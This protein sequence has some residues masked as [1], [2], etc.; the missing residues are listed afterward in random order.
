MLARRAR[1]ESHTPLRRKTRLRQRSGIAGKFAKMRKPLPRRRSTPRRRPAEYINEAYLAWLRTQPCRFPDCRNP[2]E[3]H[4]L[5]HDE[6]GA[7][8]GRNVK[9]DRRAISLCRVHH[10][11][12]LHRMPWVLRFVVH[13][14]LRAWQD[15]ELAIQRAEFLARV[16][17]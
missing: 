4:H 16:A 15:R 17:T 8:L 2:S 1:L 9:N 6:H 3:A 10:R 11:E 5:R 12:W 7:S 13:M 14:E